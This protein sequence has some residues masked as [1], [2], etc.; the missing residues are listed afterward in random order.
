MGI[1]K[2]QVILEEDE[3]KVFD[4]LEIGKVYF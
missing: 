1:Q 3:A 4:G 2:F